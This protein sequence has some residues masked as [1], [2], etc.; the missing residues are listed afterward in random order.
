[1]SHGC[2]RRDERTIV[3]TGNDIESRSPRLTRPCRQPT[4]SPHHR[5]PPGAI[6]GGEA[7]EMYTGP[8]YSRV[9]APIS[10]NQVPHSRPQVVCFWL[11]TLGCKIQYGE[12]KGGMKVERGEGAIIMIQVPASRMLWFVRASLS[13]W[14][15]AYCTATPPPSAVAVSGAAA[16]VPPLRGQAA[17]AGRGADK[18]HWK[19]QHSDLRTHP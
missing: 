19:Y 12:A 10:R 13:S 9:R 4:A 8:C 18:A 7:R 2:G 14:Q 5:T 1:M 11:Y 3:M 15:P 17:G 6:H 16:A